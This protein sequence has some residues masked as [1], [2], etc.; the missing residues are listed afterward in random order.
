M[1]EY[2]LFIF[3]CNHY[4]HQYFLYLQQ[5]YYFLNLMIEDLEKEAKELKKAIDESQLLQ[6]KVI[7]E[8]NYIKK[9]LRITELKKFKRR[10]E[11]HLF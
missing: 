5:I 1:L 9:I 11:E 4:Y 8:T 10:V 6:Q 7:Y 3:E 2:S